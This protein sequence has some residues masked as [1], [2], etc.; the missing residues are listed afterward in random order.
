MVNNFVA[1]VNGK[2]VALVDCDDNKLKKF[3]KPPPSILSLKGGHPMV[4]YIF[5]Q[6]KCIAKT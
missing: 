1:G 5:L 4:S 6:I 3:T 2:K